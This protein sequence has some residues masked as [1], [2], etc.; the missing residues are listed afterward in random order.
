MGWGRALA[1]PMTPFVDHLPRMQFNADRHDRGAILCVDV[2]PGVLNYPGHMQFGAGEMT[3]GRSGFRARFV[4][5]SDAYEDLV[6]AEY[7][8]LVP[9]LES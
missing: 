2:K 3:W 9:W 4:E 5:R 8:D 1:V 7:P 6:R